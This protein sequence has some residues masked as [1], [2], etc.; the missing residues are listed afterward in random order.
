MDDWLYH[1]VRCRT[2]Y[3]AELSKFVQ[4]FFVLL[5]RW[6]VYHRK[7]FA[8]TNF[9]VTLMGHGS[10]VMGHGSLFGWVSGSWVTGS[11]PLPTLVFTVK[12]RPSAQLFDLHG[13]VRMKIFLWERVSVYNL[14]PNFL[15]LCS[16]DM[17]PHSVSTTRRFHTRVNTHMNTS[18][19]RHI[20]V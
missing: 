15:C 6:F 20:C 9:V 17:F 2:Q 11:D 3:F 13:C 1:T 7:R 4:L 14:L 16:T 18:S 10:Y 8:S 5:C 19:G 12:R